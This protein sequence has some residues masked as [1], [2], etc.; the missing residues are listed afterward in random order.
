MRKTCSS[1]ST[2]SV[3]CICSDPQLNDFVNKFKREIVSELDLTTPLEEYPDYGLLAGVGVSSST[4]RRLSLT[5]ILGEHHPSE[6]AVFAI[7]SG[8]VQLA[9]LALFLLTIKD[10]GFMGDIVLHVPNMIPKEVS[11]F[12]VDYSEA[13]E[14]LIVYEGVLIPGED[15]TW[16]ISSFFDDQGQNITEDPR[17][18]RSISFVVFE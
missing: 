9:N 13:F 15:R 4:Q 11:K 6:N 17:P 2:L 5:P 16:T 3:H 8:N 12:L 7:V 14:N 1:N 18:P 10:V